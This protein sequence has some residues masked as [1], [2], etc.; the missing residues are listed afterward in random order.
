[1]DR[2]GLGDE[3]IALLGL[4]L[5]QVN[6]SDLFLLAFDG[7]VTSLKQV[8]NSAMGPIDVLRVYPIE[9]AHTFGEI[10]IRRFH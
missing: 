2:K 10:R 6:K 7:F 9:L 5:R 8:T 1:M 3:G 4:A